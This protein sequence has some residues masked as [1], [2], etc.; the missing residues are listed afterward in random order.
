M[1]FCTVLY[2]SFVWGISYHTIKN[3]IIEW[4]HMIRS[5]INE[6][7]ID[8]TFTI[9]ANILLRITPITSGGKKG[10]HLLQRWCNLIFFTDFRDK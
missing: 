9:I 1:L 6:N 7:F 10:I 5:R 4:I 3:E 2:N 8:K